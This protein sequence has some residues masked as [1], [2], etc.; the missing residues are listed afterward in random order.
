MPGNNPV[1]MLFI[2]VLVENNVSVPFGPLVGVGIATYCQEL[3][4]FRTLSQ[5]NLA[6]VCNK[7]VYAIEEAEGAEQ[8][9]AV[10][11]NVKQILAPVALCW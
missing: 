1:N 11:V 2:S 10:I 4:K 9:D 6:L 5:E 8:V 7:L 3:T